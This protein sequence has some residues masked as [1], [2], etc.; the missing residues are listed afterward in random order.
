MHDDQRHHPGS[1]HDEAQPPHDRSTTGHG[2]DEA[3][4]EG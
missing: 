1:S 3:C 2:E 4:I